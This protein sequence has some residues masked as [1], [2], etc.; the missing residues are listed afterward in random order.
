MP[1]WS[2]GQTLSV[3]YF[4][5]HRLVDDETVQYQ[6][7]YG[8][9]IRLFRANGF[10]V[11]DLIELQPPRDASTSYEGYASLEWARRWPAEHIWR[12]RKLG[13]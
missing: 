10:I 1:D 8:D 9:W 3:D 6:L 13:A 7:P 2:L 11:E 12:V 5:L 4:G